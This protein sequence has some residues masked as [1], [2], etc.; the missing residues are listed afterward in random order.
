MDIRAQKAEL[1]KHI[2]ELQ[3]RLQP[4]DIAAGDKKIIRRVLDLSEYR[5]AKTLFLFVSTAAEI[6]TGPLLLNALADGKRVAVPR[7]IGDGIM[8]AYVISGTEDLAEGAYGI[9]EP[10]E[11]CLPLTVEEMDF[12]V[13]PCVSCDRQGNRLGHGGGFYDRYLANVAFPTAALCR[14]QLLCGRIPSDSFD[15]AVDMVITDKKIYRRK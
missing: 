2:R 3:S 4:E 7:C 14:E 9:L 6:D 8:R 5:Q 11:T 10:Y 15:I 12:G 1:R 13:I